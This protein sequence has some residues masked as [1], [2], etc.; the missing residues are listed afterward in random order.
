[1]ISRT[2]IETIT[3]IAEERKRQAHIAY[4]E[5]IKQATRDYCSAALS[6]QLKETADKPAHSFS[7]YVSLPDTD[8]DVRLVTKDSNNS[9]YYT[10]RGDYYNLPEFE[11]FIKDHGFDVTIT[12]TTYRYNQRTSY[13]AKRITIKW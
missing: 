2:E 3:L 8:G 4:V 10:E 13:S 11:K 9:T 6:E 5:T 7:F 1:M 12:D